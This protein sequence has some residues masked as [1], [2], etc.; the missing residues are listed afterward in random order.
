MLRRYEKSWALSSYF[1]RWRRVQVLITPDLTLDGVPMTVESSWTGL[2]E[3]LEAF[4]TA[5]RVLESFELGRGDRLQLRGAHGGGGLRDLVNR[6]AGEG[7]W[8]GIGFLVQHTTKVLVRVAKIV[9]L[10]LCLDRFRA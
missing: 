3:V 6:L 8:R 10:C 5:E 9:A 1:F 7:I 4:T 2:D